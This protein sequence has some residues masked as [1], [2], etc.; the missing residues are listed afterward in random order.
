MNPVFLEDSY[1]PTVATDSNATEREALQATEADSTEGLALLPPPYL[2]K[3]QRLHPL[4]I[5]VSVMW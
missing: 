3:P 1:N 2:F 4:H 5:F